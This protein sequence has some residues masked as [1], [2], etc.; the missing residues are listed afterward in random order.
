MLALKSRD[1]VF[2]KLNLMIKLTPVFLC[3]CPLIDDK[4]HHNIVKVAV[5]LLQASGSV[6]NY[7]N[8]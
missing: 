1:V 3:I 6:V 8:C 4:L 7:D 2:T 5:E